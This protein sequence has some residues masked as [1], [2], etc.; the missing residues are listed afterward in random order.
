MYCEVF[1]LTRPNAG[2]I[3]VHFNLHNADGSVRQGPMTHG[4]N[5]VKYDETGVPV[6]ETGVQKRQRMAQEFNA[7]A[8]R[9]IQDATLVDTHF[10]AL[11][12]D[13]V[14]YRYPSAE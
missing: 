9:L 11:L 12:A 6:A 1:D 7:Y 5:V 4:F 3:M 10:D 2:R 8:E 13:A 14:G